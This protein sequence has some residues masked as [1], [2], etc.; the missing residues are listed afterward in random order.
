MPLTQLNDAERERKRCF[1]RI[2]APFTPHTVAS[3]ANRLTPGVNWRGCPK[4]HI[5]EAYARGEHSFKDIQGTNLVATA[6]L[7]L[8][9]Y[10]I[11]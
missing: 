7:H 6:K 8:Q 10:G 11:K 9:L 2:M 1:L 3:I 4:S 5:A